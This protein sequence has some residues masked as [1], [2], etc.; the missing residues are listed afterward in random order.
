MQDRRSWSLSGPA[1]GNESWTTAPIGWRQRRRPTGVAGSSRHTETEESSLFS[2]RSCDGSFNL[3]TPPPSSNT[4]DAG[5]AAD[6]LFALPQGR[7]PRS[8]VTRTGSSGIGQ[9]VNLLTFF[10]FIIHLGILQDS[11]RI[12]QDSW[13]IVH[14]FWQE[15]CWI[16]QDSCRIVLD[17]CRITQDSCRILAGL[18]NFLQDC[19]GFTCSCYPPED[20]GP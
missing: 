16:V 20:V 7:A 12:V 14:I 3:F 13:R 18:Y 9:N 11:C 1:S 10:F 15:S 8:V 2:Y 19:L 4:G 6:V 5:D 17:P